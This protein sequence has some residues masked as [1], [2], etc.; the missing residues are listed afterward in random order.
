MPIIMKNVNVTHPKPP[1]Q[2]AKKIF[3]KLGTCSQTFFH[4][5]NREF[6]RS[7]ETKERAADT[8]SGGLM[9]KGYQCGMLWGCS[10]AIGAEAYRR[11]DDLNLVAQVAVKATQNVMASF[12]SREGTVNCREITRCDFSNKLS[13]ARYFISGRF[14]HCFDLAQRWAP[15]ALESALQGLSADKDVSTL[16]TVNCASEVAR[17]MGATDEETVMV[18]GFAGGMGLCGNACGALAA[19]IWLSSLAWCREHDTKSSHKNPD[20]GRVLKAFEEESDGKIL[21]S[22]LSGQKFNTLRQHSSFVANG[23]CEDLIARLAEAN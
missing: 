1:S 7:Q 22:E 16:K 6:G 10:L 18:S 21:C 19:A 8:L 3:R 4:I 5:L 11:H 17:K 20:A 9:Q 12:E 14:L 2:E 15:E 23:G 13:F